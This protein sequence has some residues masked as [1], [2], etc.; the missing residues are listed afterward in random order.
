MSNEF[1]K[2]KDT[3]LTDQSKTISLFQYIRELNKLKQKAILNMKDYPWAF[4]LSNLPDDPEN[5]SVFYRD[6]VEDNVENEDGSRENVL[7]SVHK[8]EFQKCPEPDAILKEWLLP[9]W[10]SYRNEP[11]VK[12]FIGNSG[13]AMTCAAQQCQP[14]YL[15]SLP[16]G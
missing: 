15:S 14:V 5:I 1:R 4:A 12:E 9:G 11:E 3:E 7:L 13:R 16:E 10:D 8:P 6:R 2:D